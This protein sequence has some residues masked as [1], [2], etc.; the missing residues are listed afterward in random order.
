MSRSQFSAL[1]GTLQPSGQISG[2]ESRGGAVTEVPFPL[3]A[4]R[5]GQAVFPHPALGQESTLPK[6]DRLSKVGRRL[7][8]LNVGREVH[9]FAPLSLSLSSASGLLELRPLPSTGVTRLPR[10]YEPVRHPR[11]P[12]LSLAGVRLGSCSP[13]LGL[14]VLQQLPLCR[15]AVTITPVGPLDQIV[16]D[17]G[18]ST[19]R[20][21]PATAAF[22]E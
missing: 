10:Y 17:E 1:S 12:G 4:R 13:P 19:P 21:S 2:V 9:R 8:S 16:R 6:R 11:R 14:P 5:T 18:L 3:P 15:H 20:Y 7:R 22:P